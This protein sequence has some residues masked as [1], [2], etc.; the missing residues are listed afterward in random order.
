MVKCKQKG[1]VILI[2][3]MKL[4]LKH[5]FAFTL[6]FF[7]LFITFFTVKLYPLAT[8]LIGS[9]QP[10]SYIVLLQNDTEIRPNGG[11]TGSYAKITA[12]CKIHQLINPLSCLKLEFQD[13]YVPNGQLKSY[14]KPP[15]PIQTAFGHGTWQLANADWDPHFPS[16]AISIRWFFTKGGE[17]NPDIL[18]TLSLTD[19]KKLASIIGPFRVDALNVT[20]T[21]DNLYQLL[22]N[23]AEFNFFPGSTQKKRCSH[24]NWQS[25]FTQN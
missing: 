2:I 24:C 5:I 7:A 23:Q 25:I 21:P 1:G 6:A 16:S 19:I 18:A 17:T 20:V 12:S 14:V 13:I 9:H 15:S 4:P 10:T 8:Y 11:F 3:T 22:Q